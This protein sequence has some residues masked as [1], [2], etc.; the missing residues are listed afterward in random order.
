ML[1]QQKVM[2]F[3][4]FFKYWFYMGKIKIPNNCLFTICIFNEDSRFS[5]KILFVCTMVILRF[6]IFII[7]CILNF[8]LINDNLVYL[9]QCD[10]GKFNFLHFQH[11]TDHQNSMFW[12]HNFTKKAFL[13]PKNTY[14]LSKLA[15][16]IVFCL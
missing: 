10:F 2:C 5:L 3:D 9:Y 4:T 13:R 15:F 8:M 14:F 12:S 16:I 7:I 1:K 6:S 11:V